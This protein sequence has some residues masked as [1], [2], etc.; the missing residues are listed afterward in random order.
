MKGFVPYSRLLH[1]QP[2]SPSLL[3]NSTPFPPSSIPPS[4]SL[5]PLSA[6]LS[7]SL[8]PLPP[9][10]DPS[11]IVEVASNA[12]ENMW[13]IQKV[14]DYM[15][16]LHDDVALPWWAT[17]VLTTITVRTLFLPFNISLLRNSARLNTIRS[18]VEALGSRLKVL[19]L[20]IFPSF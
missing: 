17:I 10:L 3:E 15:N 20:F 16:M 19:F 9:P 6:S 4:P 18:Q 13:H 5:S 14:T 12:P 2:P 7:P 1:T 8:S 11:P